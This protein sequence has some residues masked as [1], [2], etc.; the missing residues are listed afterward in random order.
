MSRRQ[1]SHRRV[2]KTDTAVPQQASGVPHQSGFRRRHRGRSPRVVVT[3]GRYLHLATPNRIHEFDGIQSARQRLV[4]PGDGD[5]LPVTSD[6]SETD[7]TRTATHAGALTQPLFGKVW[8]DGSARDDAVRRPFTAW[9]TPPPV[10]AGNQICSVLA[11]RPGAVV[12]A[13][14]RKVSRPECGR[15]EAMAS[16]PASILWGRGTGCPTAVARFRTLTA[17]TLFSVLTAAKSRNSPTTLTSSKT[18]PN[19]RVGANV[20]F[21]CCC[22]VFAQRLQLLPGAPEEP[23]AE[24]RESERHNG[25]PRWP[26]E[27]G[28]DTDD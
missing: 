22:E 7:P 20:L 28:I 2:G 6:G 18:R 8:P 9:R 19:G 12:R 13:P 25:G 15:H 21:G 1:R 3:R 26:S 4:A 16:A 27:D 11:G 24:C 23:N 17:L 14:A 10:P 5:G